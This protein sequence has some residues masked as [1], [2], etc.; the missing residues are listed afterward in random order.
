[1]SEP[2]ISVSG[3]RGIIGSELTPSTVIRYISAFCSM[4]PPGPVVISRDGRESGMMLKQA[5][6]STLI[7]HG[8]TVLDA[9]VAATPTAALLVR[10]LSATA[11]IQ[12]TASH[13]P[14][15]YNGI[16]LFNHEGRVIPQDAGVLVRDAYLQ[17]KSAWKSID[18]LGIC[19]SIQ[20]P[21]QGHLDKIWKIVDGFRIG[22]RRFRVLLDSNHGSGAAL[23]R[24]LLDRL[25]CD[26]TIL[27]EEPTGKFK[28]PP[29]PL[30]DNL[31]TISE[32]VKKESYDIA[33]CQDPDAD[34]LAIIDH[35]GNY[36]G[37]E[38][39]AVLCMLNA[40]EYRQSMISRNEKIVMPSALVT[41]CASSSMSE[42]LA[43]RFGVSLHRTKV[44]EANVVDGMIEHQALYGG[45]GSG[46]PIDPRIG[47]VRDSFV[48]IA[49]VLD[50]MA[51][52]EQSIAEIVADLPKMVMIKDKIELGSISAQKAADAIQANLVAPSSSTLDGLRLDWPDAWLLVR[53]SNT[54]PIIRFICEAESKDRALALID[55][56]K[57]IVGK[58][59]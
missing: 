40:L 17:N 53:G 41:N 55:S 39:T 56:A 27:G 49:S 23:G 45:E 28:H 31:Q 36:I 12:I 59:S 34:R 14:R 3:L 51:R 21:H 22:K 38:Y 15:A 5:A 2:I 7:G 57:S 25:N 18:G 42:K 54:E 43:E 44:G 1:M 48:G 33:F 16:K 50:L 35:Q 24:L 30:A 47:W 11:G 10:M 20:D 19:E 32:L 29:E 52:R 9:D 13:N 8:K 58:I 6:I 26:F 46:G 37:E 4:L